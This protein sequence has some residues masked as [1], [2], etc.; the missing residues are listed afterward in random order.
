M[1]NPVTHSMDDEAIRTFLDGQRTGV[2]SLAEGSDAYAVPVSFTF[3]EASEA[4]YFRLGYGP[5]SLKREYVDATDRTTFV[6][7][8]ETDAGWRSVLARGPLEELD[9]SAERHARYPRGT[10]RPEVQRAVRDLEIPFY[11]VFEDPDD[12]EFTLVRLAA[13]EITGVVETETR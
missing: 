1:G 4:F 6:V 12:V 3:D 9:T 11:Q 13:D 5:D 2:L 10:D 7:H 8:G